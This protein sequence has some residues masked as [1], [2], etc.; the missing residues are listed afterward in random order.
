ML[1]KKFYTF[2]LIVFF[3][4]S[5]VSRSWAN[6]A[7]CTDPGDLFWLGNV[8]YQVI[9]EGPDGSCY[10]RVV[11]KCTLPSP[12]P[13]VGPLVA[14]AVESGSLLG[15]AAVGVGGACL[16]I[17]AMAAFDSACPGLRERMYEADPGIFHGCKL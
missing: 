17:G 6:D 10:F 2:V 11:M 15:A 12:A 5:T 8:L 14:P 9:Y 4:L 16:M 7:M 1:V 3:G 13:V